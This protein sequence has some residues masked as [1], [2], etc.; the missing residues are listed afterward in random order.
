MPQ[1][2]LTSVAIPL[3][4]KRTSTGAGSDAPRKGNILAIHG[5]SPENP[6]FFQLFVQTVQTA[7]GFNGGKA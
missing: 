5:V 1:K 3:Y 6:N 7:H 2:F 4:N